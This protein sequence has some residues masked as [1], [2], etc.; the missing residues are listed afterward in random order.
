M[1]I[2]LFD[3]DDGVIRMRCPNCGSRNPIITGAKGEYNVLFPSCG[4]NEKLLDNG[5]IHVLAECRVRKRKK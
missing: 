1:A 5:Q 4:A 3:G 2:F